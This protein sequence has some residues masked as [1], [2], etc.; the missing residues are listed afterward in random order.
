[1]IYSFLLLSFFLF[2]LLF[3]LLIIY[4]YRN[5]IEFTKNEG[6]KKGRNETTTD[7]PF[8]LFLCYSSFERKK[9]EEIKIKKE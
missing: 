3:L 8:F 5:S 4:R 9:E 6:R 2:T 1:M 7:D